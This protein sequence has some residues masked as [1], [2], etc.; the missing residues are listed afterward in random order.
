[1]LQLLH[2]LKSLREDHSG[3]KRTVSL[4]GD[5]MDLFP[6]NYKCVRGES[7]IFKEQ[8]LWEVL[9]VTPKS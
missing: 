8:K 2:L 7:M 3:F 4:Q 9:G 6:D 1:M 5:C